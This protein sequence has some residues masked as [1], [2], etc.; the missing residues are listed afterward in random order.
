MERWPAALLLLIAAF[1]AG[2]IS[3]GCGAESPSGC[4]THTAP[5]P[6]YEA[7]CIASG[8]HITANR[9]LETC[10]W[11]PSYC[12]DDS[13]APLEI[14]N[15]QPSATPTPAFTPVPTTPPGG[16]PENLCDSD[17]DCFRTGCSSEVCAN[18]DVITTC[19]YRSDYA[20][21]QYASCGCVG[22]RCAWDYPPGYEQCIFN[23]MAKVNCSSDA[24]CGAGGKCFEGVCALACGGEDHVRCADGYSCVVGENQ[25]VGACARPAPTPAPSATPAA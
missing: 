13:G 19:M 23:L 3:S 12:A 20:C 17:D 10:C 11:G 14:S 5:A 6:W 24:Q 22:Q 7:E 2:C 25:T 4:P 21:L 15:P 18:H 8:G 1:S 9:N 16:P